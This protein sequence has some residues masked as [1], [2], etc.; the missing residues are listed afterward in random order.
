MAPRSWMVWVSAAGVIGEVD[1]ETEQDAL[2]AARTKYGRN[3]KRPANPEDNDA[4]FIYV[5]DTFNVTALPT[6]QERE[7]GWRSEAA[8]KIVVAMAGISVVF[9]MF[10]GWSGLKLGAILGALC[11]AYWVWKGDA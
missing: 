2:H 1:A 4:N 9:V 7:K 6:L 8:I 3:G 11:G 10:T 5:D